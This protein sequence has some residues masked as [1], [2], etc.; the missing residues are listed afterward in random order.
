M[1]LAPDTLQCDDLP[2][3]NDRVESERLR[4]KKLSETGRFFVFDS[5]HEYSTVSIEKV[6]LFA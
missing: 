3:G 4:V 6:F 5:K 2:I 1:I